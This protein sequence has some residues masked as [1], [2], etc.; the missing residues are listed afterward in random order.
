MCHKYL[1][2]VFTIENQ[3]SQIE[4]VLFLNISFA[5]AELWLAS[6]KH[7]PLLTV[8][9][10]DNLKCDFGLKITLGVVGVEQLLLLL[11]N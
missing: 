7:V 10:C 4:R 9:V 6:Q 1:C 5:Y 11:L 2:K 8:I 3:L